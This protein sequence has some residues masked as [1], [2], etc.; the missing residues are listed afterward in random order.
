MFSKEKQGVSEYQFQELVSAIKEFLGA[1]EILISTIV[2]KLPHYPSEKIIATI[3]FMID[4]GEVV[5]R[6]D[7][8]K[9]GKI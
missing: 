4:R 7:K 1:E 6:L 5:L 9:M 8:I 2:D 3:R